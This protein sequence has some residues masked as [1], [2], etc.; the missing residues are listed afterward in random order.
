MVDTYVNHRGTPFE[1]VAKPLQ[2]IAQSSA[3]LVRLSLTEEFF[4]SQALK[5]PMQ[6]EVPVRDKTGI[7]ARPVR[8]DHN[9]QVKNAFALTFERYEKAF[10]ELAKI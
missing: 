5:K 9:A 6:F 2:Q 7:K 4:M 3:S 8:G 10:E 1:T